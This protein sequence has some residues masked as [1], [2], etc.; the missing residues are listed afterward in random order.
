MFGKKKKFQEQPL[1]YWEELSC[2]M[3]IPEN[4]EKLPDSEQAVAAINNIDGVKVNHSKQSDKS[5]AFLVNFDYDG[6]EYEAVFEAGEFSLPES[7]LYTMRTF[8]PAETE[9]MK[10]A[11]TA[12][13]FSMRF[14]K[15]PKKFYHVQLKLAA[16]VV[17][18]LIGLV[19]ESA[20]RVLPPKWVK[21]AAKSKVVPA[22]QDLFSIQAVSGAGNSV[23]LHTHGLCRF[24]LTEIEILDSD[25]EHFND[26]YNLLNAYGVYLLDMQEN[27]DPHKDP[28]YIGLL[29]GKI[30]VVAICRSW[31]EALSEYKKLELGGE[32]DRE[33][34]HNTRTSPVFLYKSED[35]MNKDVLS[36]VS[37]YNNNYAN[38]PVY[39]FSN[40]ETERMKS[41]AEER[42]DYLKKAFENNADKI[43]IKIGLQ[44]DGENIGEKEHI[45]FELVSINGEK[46][47]AKLMHEPYNVSGIHTGDEREFTVADVTDWV[48]YTG[49]FAVSP[50]D[51]YLLEERD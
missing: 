42:F 29:E 2:F 33:N 18:D 14:K 19:D 51:V 34:A 32:R 15:D 7:Y 25:S 28:A 12:M 36:K 5:C 13:N 37:I 50:N 31:T 21:L 3:A 10:N 11:H 43:L 1:G 46:F 39:F 45:W 17:P 20:E 16:A 22:A 49:N 35:D 47:T 44:T 9:K 24:G 23:W 4:E 48:I 26:H 38:N 41:L 40:E 8:T 30:P 27:F 6:E